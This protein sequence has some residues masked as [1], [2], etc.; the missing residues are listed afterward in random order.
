MQFPLELINM[1][2]QKAN[3]LIDLL[4][5]AITDLSHFSVDNDDMFDVQIPRLEELVKELR[6][7]L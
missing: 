5:D 7:Q 1:D 3:D 4:E 2:K 6:K